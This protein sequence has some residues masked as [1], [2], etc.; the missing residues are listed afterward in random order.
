MSVKELK[1]FEAGKLDSIRL[2]QGSEE[3]SK[4]F[5][6]MA[7][8]NKKT[9]A[10]LIN[11]ETLQFPTLYL[12]KPALVRTGLLT[13]LS[14]KY[15]KAVRLANAILRKDTAC[16]E[17]LV[18]NCNIEVQET[19][20]WILLTGC[21]DDGLDNRYDELMELSA[22]LLVRHYSDSSILPA[23]ADML[24]KRYKKGLLVHNLVWAFFE[25]RNPD[26]LL[27][28]ANYLYSQDSRDYE[29]ACKLLN[30][31]PYVESNRYTT[32]AK[33]YYEVSQWIR[34]N[35]MFLYRT[36]ECLHLT[37]NPIPYALSSEA[38]YLCK[39][40]SPSNG[41]PFRDYSEEE[42]GILS[43]FRALEP[44]IRLQLAGFSYFLYRRN[45]H[46]WNQWIHFSIEDQLKSMKMAMG[47]R[48]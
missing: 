27:L 19:L 32:P 16:V 41:K 39:P 26:S 13:R 12:L 20:K 3:V 8:A 42:E 2:A 5:G 48:M 10:A 1:E 11:D 9:A 22:A 18:K 28:L 31:I 40:V 7:A 21:A 15:L 46:Q 38:K 4:Y 6:K 24:F 33:M 14:N 35:S 30:F 47:G 23:V 44:E 37:A 34:E 25:A 29:F 43:R 17:Y 36:E 45:M